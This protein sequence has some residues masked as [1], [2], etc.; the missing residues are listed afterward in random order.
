MAE[1]L[2]IVESPAKAKTIEKYLG[3]NFIVKSS[4]GHIRDL[5]KKNYGIDIENDFAPKYI[6]DT[7]KKKV[8]AELKK[9]VDKAKFVWLAS[10]EDREGE[11]I[12]WHLSEVLKLKKETTKRIVFN[13]VTK[14]AILKA[15][16]NPRDID[17]NLVNA[18]QARRI[19]DRL[20]GFE[21]SEVLWKKVKSQLSAGR[22]QSVAVRLLVEREREI[23]AFEA[24]SSFKVT[25]IFNV[26]D[27]NGKFVELKAE[28][29]R[30]LKDKNEA[31]E[32]IEKCKISDFII[33]SIETKPTKK[34]PSAPFTTST[35]QQEASRKLG[36]SVAQTMTLAQKLYEEG[37][38]TYMRTDSVNLSDEALNN[39]KEY[40]LKNFGEKYSNPKKYQTKTK[41]AQE[42]HEAIRPTSMRIN[43]SSDRREQKLYELIFNRTLASQMS[44]AKFEKTTV[45]IQISNSSDTFIAVGEVL[46][47]EGFL[48]AY[49]Y[50]NEDEEQEET[51][52]LP[53]VSENQKLN[54]KT[55]NATE[56]FSTYSPR[57]TEASLVRKLEEL[58]IGRPSTYAPI[59]ST[60]QKRGYVVKEDRDGIKRKY[61]E[62]LLLN[63][64][65]EAKEKQE[66]AN[67][68]KKKL[69]PTDIAM[70]VNDFLVENFNTVLNY[71][72]TATVE[73]DFDEIAEGNL[74]W[75][76][77]L[78]TF[79]SKFH[80]DIKNTVEK[81][82]RKTGERD[83]GIDPKTGKK[84]ITRIG[85]FGPIVQL[86][87]GSEDEKPQYASLRKDQH[88]ETITLEEAI[89]LLN[90]D[91]NGKLLGIDPKSGKPIYARLGKFGAMVQKG[92]LDDKDKPVYASLLKG[93][94]LSQ[95][96][97]E[98]ALA[99]FQLPRDLGEFENEKITVGVG[100]F[101][102]FVR[103]KSQFTSLKKTD[104]PLSLTLERAIELI[105]EKKLAD[106]KK[107]I[108]EFP[109]DINLKIIKD[110]WGKPCIFFKKKYIR[111]PKELEPQ[112]LTY[113]DCIK[114]INE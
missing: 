28:L 38:I 79:Y 74:I 69:F 82:D 98:E 3:K 13:E 66:I 25:A 35:L 18:Q 89:E 93:Q 47:F 2:V 103:H 108:K 26:P 58:G 21:L 16:E 84:I 24:V 48:K 39:A 11:A 101:G 110:R 104:D 87:E 105:I 55:I 23:F 63:N 8:V 29:N 19:L 61:F 68:E 59:I 81:A 40:I 5:S 32:F 36:Y 88:I 41:G 99:L 33:K 60:I 75:N 96:T 17:I 46:K 102:P 27:K 52:L 57:Y 76:K 83:L 20:V 44:D 114:L 51:I 72:F 111:I 90:S 54:Y 7:G 4:F 95:I 10:D 42:A 113:D 53:S 112:D 78:G 67:I 6:I 14:S 56:K 22:V 97:F 15:I 80:S 37:N 62:I 70:V 50:V 64:E 45:S 77:M 94:S 100:K 49:G 73:K 92:N 30:K 106:Q 107:L 43:V 86:G 12:A 91:N 65:V 34:S 1:N 31:L 109:E 9:E 71:N 85:R